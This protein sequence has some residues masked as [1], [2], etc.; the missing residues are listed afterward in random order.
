MRAL[1]R[2]LDRALLHRGL[3]EL[4]DADLGRSAIVFAPH[5]DDEALGCGGTIIRKKRA[6]AVVKV[7]FLTDGSMSHARLMPPEE[8]RALRREEAL[9]AAEAMG[10]ARGDVTFCDLKDGQLSANE[11]AGVAKVS[12]ILRR[13][14]PAEVF[15]T[16][17]QDGPADHHATTRIVLAALRETGQP[18]TVYEYPIWFWTHWPWVPLWGGLRDRLRN[19]KKGVRDSRGMW[20]DFNCFVRIDAVRDLKRKA[21]DAHRSQMTR[22]KPDPGWLTLPDAG[23]GE[24]LPCFFGDREIFYR[25]TV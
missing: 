23:E 5:Q 2:R 21:L 15:V 20:R 1:F 8:M 11:P 14:Q 16:Y 22:L 6:G 7:V 24:W 13:E 25:H 3:T 19:L 9:A 10:L 12:D 4:G 17:Y 18:A